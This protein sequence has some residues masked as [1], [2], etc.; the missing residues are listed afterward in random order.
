MAGGRRV[1]D[2]ASL[3]IAAGE[4]VLL[5]G[6]SGAG[7][8]TLAAILGGRRRLDSGLLLLW[9]LDLATLGGGRRSGG[10]SWQ[11]RVVAV[12]QLH[13]NH[14]FGETLAWNLLMG[15]GWP[16]SDGDLAE[17]AAVCRELGL[18]ELLARLPAGLEQRIGEAGWRLSDGE[19]SRVC[20]ARAVLQEPDLVIVD[21]G[22]AALDPEARLRVLNAVARR[23]RTLVVIAH[24]EADGGW[25][26][27][28]K[29]EG[30]VNKR[31]W[32]RRGESGRG[33]GGEGGADP[34]G[35]QRIIGAT[36]CRPGRART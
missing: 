24:A 4:R 12:P 6:P 18:G 17:A 32:S 19:A 28:V 23:V 5:S 35:N 21:E 29:G 14:I 36:S 7:K 3:V 1:L 8:S 33:G 25:G 10:G 2:G 16:P 9:G 34:A 11:R 30:V 22:L 27:R 15:R 26:E 31:E 20:L 13:D